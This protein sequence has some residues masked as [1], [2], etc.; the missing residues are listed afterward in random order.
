MYGLTAIRIGPIYV[1]KTGTVKNA[2]KAAASGTLLFVGS[3]DKYIVVPVSE[4]QVVQEGG[5]V[6]VTQADHIRDCG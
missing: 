4:T 1:C 2:C 3:A 5:I 6:H